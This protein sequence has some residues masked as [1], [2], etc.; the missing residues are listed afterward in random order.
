M[1]RMLVAVALFALLCSAAM[2]ATT[3]GQ[4]VNITVNEVAM[5]DGINDADIPAAAFVISAPT[6]AGQEPK[7]NGV[8]HVNETAG[9]YVQYTSVLPSGGGARKITCGLTAV[10][11]GLKMEVMAATAVA[12]NGTVGSGSAY[13]NI[14]ASSVDLVTGIGSCWT[15]TTGTSG[16]KVQWRCTVDDIANLKAQSITPMTATFTITPAS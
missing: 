3:A 2:A 13:A 1:A 11:G 7:V 14:D 6:A 9:D 10:P 8:A 16:V 5:I 15:D 4:T 12:G